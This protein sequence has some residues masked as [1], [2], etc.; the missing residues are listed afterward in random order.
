MTSPYLRILKHPI[1]AAPLFALAIAPTPS[2]AGDKITFVSFHVPPF[3]I[4]GGQRVGFVRE[5]ARELS[6]RVG[7]SMKVGY[8]KSPKAALKIVKTRPNT[9]I[10][11]LAR[12]KKREPHFLWLQKVRDVPLFFASAPGKSRIQTI[13]QAKA[14]VAIGVRRGFAVRDLKKRGF[15]NLVIVRT[16]EENAK[17][18]AAGRIAAWYA[19]E[20]EILYTWRTTG[21]KGRLGRGLTTRIVQS[22]IA[23]SKS[24]PLV[25]V[26]RWRS[27][28]ADMQREGLIERIVESYLGP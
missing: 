26:A 20:P 4:K 11:P 15:K 18:L 25:N 19:P 3:S 5:I 28:F 27:A 6:R 1:L 13:A 22:Y 9:L 24:S 12:T 17:A 23:S 14:A 2:L 8:A 10:F 16:P 7:I 21:Q